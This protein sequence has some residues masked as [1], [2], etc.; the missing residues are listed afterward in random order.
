MAHIITVQTYG[1]VEAPP[2]DP[3]CEKGIYLHTYILASD[4][5]W[6]TIV[7]SRP[8]ARKWRAGVGGF[9]RRGMFRSEIVIAV[10]IGLL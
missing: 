5:A 4:S 1:P 3:R 7:A 10:Y 2:S 8:R 6:F 9:L